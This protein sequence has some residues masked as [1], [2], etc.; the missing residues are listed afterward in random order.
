MKQI[1]GR[2]LLQPNKDFPADCEMLDYLQTNTHIVS[3]IGN[4]AG[5]KAVLLGCDSMDNGARRAE[6]YVFLHTQEHPEGEVLF[7]EGGAVGSGMYLK[8]EV[9][10]VQAQGYDYP[11]AYVRRSLAPG[12]GEENYRWEDF[13]EAQSLPALDAELAALRKTLADMKP[14]PL[15]MVE[16]WAGRGVPDGYLLCE[17]QQLRQTDYPEL[18]AAIGSAFNNG[19]DCNGRKL[20]TSPNF[21]R[22]PDLRGRFVV[23]YYGSDDDYKTLGAVGGKKTH[24]LTVEELPAH[25]H[26]LF[27]QHAGNRFT[28][29]GSANAL[30]EG[31]GHTYS[32]GGNKPHENRP[33][34]YALAYIM[35]TK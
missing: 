32:T 24:Q 6:G 14:S 22:L 12:V 35:R 29:G 13:R 11:Q 19:Y 30:N 9:I 10:S 18:F 17:G 27:L 28:G 8:Q 33:P 4:I 15:G 21:F 7:W 34:Y 3:I 23:G 16:M 20:T 25:D 31:D 1:H 2:Y 5:N 26:G